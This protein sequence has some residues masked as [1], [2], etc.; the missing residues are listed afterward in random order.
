MSKQKKQPVMVTSF[1]RDAA[2]A[3]LDDVQ[4]AVKYP[5]LSECMMPIFDGS[6]LARSA[7][8]LTITVEG[9]HW[10]VRLDCPTEVLV[11]SLA[12]ASLVDVLAVFEE[13]L[14]SGQVV[15]SPGWKRNKEPLPTI[16]DVI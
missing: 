5:R 3:R 8:K 9:A 13:Y 10:R 15:W 12:A 16:D 6:K 2:G 4:A 1:L 7:G 14:D 11:C